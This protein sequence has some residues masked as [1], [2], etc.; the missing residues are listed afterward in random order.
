MPLSG[1]SKLVA[2]ASK[3]V[4]STCTNI[5]G[6]YFFVT[7]RLTHT[8]KKR[9]YAIHLLGCNSSTLNNSPLGCNSEPKMGV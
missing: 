4:N 1:Q 9:V 8:V 7:F 6:T 3:Q 2:R 5:D